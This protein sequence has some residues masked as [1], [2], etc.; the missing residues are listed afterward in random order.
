VVIQLNFRQM[1]GQCRTV[2]DMHRN[3][4]LLTVEAEMHVRVRALNHQEYGAKQENSEFGAS[5]HIAKG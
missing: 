2:F 4:R 1:L 5:G 3:G